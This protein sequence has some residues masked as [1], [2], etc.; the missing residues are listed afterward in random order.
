M[1]CNI[2]FY[3]Y[4]II[5]FLEIFGNMIRRADLFVEV[6]RKKRKK[7]EKSHFHLILFMKLMYTQNLNLISFKKNSDKTISHI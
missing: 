1:V 7:L 3:Q 2:F 5:L 6:Y 4:S